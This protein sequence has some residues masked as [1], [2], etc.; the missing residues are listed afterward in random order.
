LVIKYE[1]PNSPRKWS[2]V[3]AC[4]LW[5]AGIAATISIKNTNVSRFSLHCETVVLSVLSVTL[6]YCRQTVGWIKMPLSTEVG[7]LPSDTV[8][9]GDAAPTYGNW[10]SSLC[11]FR[12]I[13]TSG[14]RVRASRASFIAFFCNIVRQIL[15]LLTVE[16]SIDV[17]RRSRTLFPVLPKS[18]VVLTTKRW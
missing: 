13:S 12:H 14:F 10:H 9:D 16:V 17:K 6:V 7:L 2:R 1:S 3:F 11:G 4:T 18:G 15:H 8:L 5:Q